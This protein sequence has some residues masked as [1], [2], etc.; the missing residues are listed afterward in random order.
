[1]IYLLFGQTLKRN[2][3]SVLDSLIRRKTHFGI[4]MESGKY[5]ERDKIIFPIIFNQRNVDI[6]KV[7]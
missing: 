3:G 1:M 7:I 5:V 4:N 6:C 2:S